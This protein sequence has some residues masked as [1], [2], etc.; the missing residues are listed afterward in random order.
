[1]ENKSVRTRF[2][3]SPTG[4][5]HIG[6]LRT[7]L[8]A[9]LFA[10]HNNGTVVLRIEDT[11]QTRKVEGAVE[12]L[13]Q[14][15]GGLGVQFDEGP[16]LDHDKISIRG[17]HGPYIQSERLDLYKKYALELV[18]NDKAYYCFCTQERLDELR[19]EQTALKK[20]P[21]Y[22]GL[23]KKLS[24]EEVDAKLG[25]GESY[26]IRQA[27]AS[28]GTTTIHDLVYGD[29]TYENELLDDQVLLKSDGFPTYHLAVVVDDHL[30]EI[31]HVI[32]AEEWI[33]STPK[34]LLL[35]EAFGW[36]P[37]AFA[38]LPLIVNPDKSKLSKRQGDVAVEDF[39]KKGYL[40]EALINFVALLGWNPK[41]E[42]EMFT[43]QELIEQFDLIKVNRAS[44]VFDTVKLDWMNSLYLRK[45][46]NEQ[47]LELL[48]P[49]LSSTGINLADYSQEFLLTMV[50]IEK[51]RLKNLSQITENTGFYFTKPELNVDMLI[52]KKSDRA[53]AKSKLTALHDWLE[54]IEVVD[55]DKENIES[56]T[57]AWILDQG[58]DTGSV[59]WPF[60]VALTG[61]EKSPSPFEVAG[62]LVLG[63][64][65][66]EV[67]SRLKEA[68]NIL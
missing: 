14:V 67:L 19:K 12:N 53:D 6:S 68:I 21:M 38:H 15:L 32:R 26:V 40:P 9:F 17:D 47:L 46:T 3:P 31:T 29:I 30:M 24:K 49:Y 2:A 33:P 48:S 57:K 39:L 16:F 42:Q 23:C 5:V 51:E 45:L 63:K 56:K 36:E 58:F 22:D 66:E 7:S 41:T 62:C 8:F 54:T 34:H 20:P 4:Y 18:E 50:N 52:W 27:I 25:S 64:G 28:T 35:F 37:P 59:L 11:D 43:L 60:R 44:A 10:K 55:F 1:M 13:I 65:K 61:L